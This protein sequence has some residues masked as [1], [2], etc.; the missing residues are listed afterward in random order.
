MMSPVLTSWNIDFVETTKLGGWLA[1]S[2]CW[3][4]FAHVPLGWLINTQMCPAYLQ[5][6]TFRLQV[7][8]KMWC[9]NWDNK[10]ILNL[11]LSEV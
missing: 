7:S 10:D 11:Y 1:F 4:L 3:P 8:S 6:N 9:T 2:L 5:A